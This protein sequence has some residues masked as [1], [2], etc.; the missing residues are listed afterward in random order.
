MH[1]HDIDR[2]AVFRRFLEESQG[3]L[4]A[5]VEALGTLEKRP[6]DPDALTALFR[7]A[8]TLRG[9]ADTLGLADLAEVT[10][11]VEEILARLRAGTLGA[12]HQV[13]DLLLRSVEALREMLAKAGG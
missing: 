7:A 4:A 10:S 9:N 11:Q 1:D 6:G 13:L 3:R 12:S 5:M 2:D 8:H